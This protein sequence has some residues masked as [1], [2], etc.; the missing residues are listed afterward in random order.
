MLLYSTPPASTERPQI[1]ATALLY[2]DAADLA[3]AL[4]LL[5]DKPLTMEP[6]MLPLQKANEQARMLGWAVHD[7][8]ISFTPDHLWNQLFPLPPPA[9]TPTHLAHDA[10]PRPTLAQQVLD[11]PSATLLVIYGSAPLM[12]DCLLTLRTSNFVDLDLYAISPPPA[13]RAM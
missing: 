13:S 8:R 1:M 3:C 11:T 10:S 12:Q 6:L 7:A 2:R 5:Q 9:H 4:Q